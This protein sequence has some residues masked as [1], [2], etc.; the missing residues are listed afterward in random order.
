MVIYSSSEMTKAFYLVVGQ[1]KLL[2][3]RSEWEN[4]VLLLVSS[5]LLLLFVVY[6]HI[7]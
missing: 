6:N 2:L 5:L 1:E 7:R 4:A 3:Y